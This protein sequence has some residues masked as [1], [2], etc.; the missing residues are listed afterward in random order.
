MTIL[1]TCEAFG[2]PPS[3]AWAEIYE[4][5]P[6]G[7]VEELLEKRAYK[8]AYRAVQRDPVGKH[9]SD[10]HWTSL[11]EE[12]EA[13]LAHEKLKERRGDSAAGVA[14]VGATDDDHPVGVGND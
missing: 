6:A 9:R 4:R 10:D 8:E 2:I 1:N 5:N 7:W 11:V 13:E 12:I 14:G 3:E